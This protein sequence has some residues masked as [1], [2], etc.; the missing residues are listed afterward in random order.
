MKQFDDR[1]T[2]HP[3]PGDECEYCGGRRDSKYT[4]LFI[5]VLDPF[6]EAL[7]ICESCEDEGRGMK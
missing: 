1:G 6:N 4:D 7:Y 2:P 3:E 5:E